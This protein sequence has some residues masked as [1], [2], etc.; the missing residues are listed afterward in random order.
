MEKIHDFRKKSPNSRLVVACSRHRATMHLYTIYPYRV[1]FLES[2]LVAPRPAG[3]DATR[4]RATS[5]LCARRAWR[6][7]VGNGS[8]ALEYIMVALGDWELPLELFRRPDRAPRARDARAGTIDNSRDASAR[9][10]DSPRGARALDAG[11]GS[12]SHND[13][14]QFGDV[15]QAT[16]PDEFD[17]EDSV[18]VREARRPPWTI[19]EI[20]SS[21]AT[22]EIMRMPPVGRS[23]CSMRCLSR[24]NRLAPLFLSNAKSAL[25]RARVEHTSPTHLR[26][27][28][29]RRGAPD[30]YDKTLRR[31]LDE[32]DANFSACANAK[33]VIV[34][35]KKRYALQRANGI[36]N[37]YKCIVNR[38]ED[39]EA[40]VVGGALTELRRPRRCCKRDCTINCIQNSASLSFWLRKYKAT[41]GKRKYISEILMEFYCAYPSACVEVARR[42][43]GAANKTAIKFKSLAKNPETAC[44]PRHGLCDFFQHTEPWNFNAARYERVFNFMDVNTIGHPTDHIP[45]ARINPSSGATNLNGLWRAYRLTTFDPVKATLD[46]I[47]RSTFLDAVRAWRHSKGFEKIIPSAADHNVCGTCKK[48]TLAHDRLCFQYNEAIARGEQDPSDFL[49]AMRRRAQIIVMATAKHRI[50]DLKCRQSVEFWKNAAIASVEVAQEEWRRRDSALIGDDHGPGHDVVSRRCV[51]DLVHIDGETSRPI[52]HVLLESNAE[53]LT[54]YYIRNVGCYSYAHGTMTNFLLDHGVN[55]EDTSL[56]CDVVLLL[57]LKSES[58]NILVL[59]MDRFAAN[60]STVLV[61]FL[62]FCVDDLKLFA[63]AGVNY[64]ASCHGKGPADAAFGT[65][66]KIHATKILFSADQY[67]YEISSRVNQ[68]NGLVTE[69]ATILSATAL[70][71]W[72]SWVNMYTGKIAPLHASFKVL[73]REFNEVFVVREEIMSNSDVDDEVKARLK[74]FIAPPGWVKFRQFEDGETH[75]V[76]FRPALTVAA[77]V[78]KPLPRLKDTRIPVAEDGQN[79]TESELNAVKWALSNRPSHK[80]N[81]FNFCKN[82]DM[83]DKASSEVI[84][85]VGLVPHG[86]VDEYDPRVQCLNHVERLPA[87]RENQPATGP[88]CP[89]VLYTNC[90]RGRKES[91]V[92]DLIFVDHRRAGEPYLP[93]VLG[94]QSRFYDAMLHFGSTVRETPDQIVRIVDLVAHA[95]RD[96]FTFDSPAPTCSLRDWAMLRRTDFGR[97]APFRHPPRSFTIDDF[98]NSPVILKQLMVRREQRE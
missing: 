97:T 31:I 90:L 32:L 28:R 84:Y 69:S 36:W 46:D 85:S 7:S 76:C 86:Y 94:K 65:H 30:A 25:Q 5:P 96:T 48:L 22:L 87:V 68:N 60:V 6:Q 26:A 72:K 24:I 8:P 82:R 83:L 54:G 75:A 12:G 23:C 61:A 17:R 81:G 89:P 56:L 43:F 34:S 88:V 70:S 62:Q 4:S 33:R 52:P 95:T 41:R 20:A 27:W 10:E 37:R 18:E 3:N 51:V 91:D 9:L 16:P 21:S 78:G 93:M 53:S 29:R 38:F 11:S 50:K 59:N 13:I 58:K 15:V 64:F 2:A 45:T 73:T 42:L 35:N 47:P 63:A 66:H 98:G 74:P 44:V 40:A 77:P 79:P 19:E 80:K 57:A 67:A 1:P 71:D 14:H 55:K 39:A 92:S 49:L